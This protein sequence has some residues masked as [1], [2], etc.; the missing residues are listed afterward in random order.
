MTTYKFIVRDKNDQ[1]VALL[2]SARNRKWEVYLNKSGSASFTISPSDEKVTGDVFLMGNKELHI[3]R[4]ETKIWAGEM[5]L[6]QVEVNND[7]VEKMTVSAKGFIELLKYKHVGT[8]AS[9]RIWT[10]TDLSQIAWEA[11]DE[12]QTGDNATLGITQ[13]DLAVARVGD[14]KGEYK[15]LKDFIE[16]TSN[17][18]WD[19]AIDF[20]IDANKQ[21]STWYPKRGRVLEDVV[22][23][24]GVNIVSFKEEQDST[25][26]ANRVIALGEGEGEEQFTAQSDDV[27]S[28]EIYGVR[29]GTISHTDANK[30]STLQKHADKYLAENKTQRRILSLRT[31]GDLSPQIGAY[32][33]GDTVKVKIDY[34]I[35]SIDSY[36]RIYGIKVQ[37][38]DE[39]EEDVELVL[40]PA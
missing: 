4:N 19:D 30:V 10:D 37:I 12:A 15:N 23:E 7:G 35:V 26:M 34:G 16:D 27:S 33:L 25:D 24:W 39:G 38:S 2:D 36:F 11:I 32:W 28:Q 29:E 22:F 14:R 31:K 6:R 3:F 1:D 5:Y 21:F 40:N 20:D 18:T 9:P 13:G 8:S 17:L